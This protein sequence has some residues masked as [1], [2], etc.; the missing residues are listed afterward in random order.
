MKANS[1][2]QAALLRAPVQLVIPSGARNLA[3]SVSDS[4]RIS[5]RELNLVRPNGP[6]TLNPSF[7]NIDAVPWV[8]SFPKA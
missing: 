5:T 3:L 2:A 4:F 6:A 1:Q 8:D 7:S